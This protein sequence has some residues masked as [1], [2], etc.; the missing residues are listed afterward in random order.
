MG[1]TRT[2]FAAKSAPMPGPS[3]TL[4]D[5][6]QRLT[7]RL[8]DFGRLDEVWPRGPSAIERAEI[9]RQREDALS[10][11]AALRDR[12]ITSRAKTLAD[13]AVQ[14]RR[15][16]VMAEETPRPRVLLGSPDVR[17]LIASL[18]AVVEREAGNEAARK[19]NFL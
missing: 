9:G 14:L 17:G 16:V 10:G 19:R 8:L 5:L 2:D 15:L 4:V 3:E 11:I 7:E 1:T 12:I 18:L 6:E 13:A